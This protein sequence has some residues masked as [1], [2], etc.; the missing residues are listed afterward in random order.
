MEAPRQEIHLPLHLGRALRL[1][2]P[3]SASQTRGEDQHPRASQTATWVLRATASS[4]KA[5]DNKY[6]RIK[7]SVLATHTI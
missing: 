2:W 6:T 4:G 7:I 1:P 3:L 5:N